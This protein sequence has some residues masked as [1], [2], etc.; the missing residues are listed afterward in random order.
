MG[1]AFA[2]EW[3]LYRAITCYKR[4][5]LLFPIDGPLERK[6]QIEYDI[7]LCYYLGN[8]PCDVIACFEKGAISQASSSFPAF[9]Q[10]LLIVY[11]AYLQEGNSERAECVLEIIHKFSPDTEEDL[12][13]YTAFKEGDDQKV[14]FAIANHRD[15]EELAQKFY[16][17]EREKKSPKKAQ[18][19]NT[20][21]PGAGY[22]YVGEKKA[23]FTSFM[24][25]ALF[26]AASYQFFSRGYPAAGAI[27][28]SLELGWYFGG[29]NGAGIEA[30]S[31]NARLFEGFGRRILC[32]KS[33]FPVLMF[34]TSF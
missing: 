25:N 3:D 22:Y 5:L 1:G 24:I 13:L 8:K 31:Y 18:L 16:C 34:E 4:A 30:Q 9:N 27:T 32:Q 7:L 28:A 6:E 15:S 20:F 14:A 17:Y 23:A 19:L 29:I 2:R 10:L 26:T 12:S 11:D 21:L 33:A